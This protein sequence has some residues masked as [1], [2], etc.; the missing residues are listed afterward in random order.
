MARA[1][2]SFVCSECGHA[3]PKWQGRCPDCGAWNTMAEERIAP[4]ARAT[5]AARRPAAGVPLREVDAVAVRRLATGIGELDRV[6]GGGLVPGSL[7]LIG[8]SPGIGKSTL[9]TMA[10]AN[11]AAAGRSVLY[12]SAEESPAQVRL[13]AERLAPAALD[14]PVLAETA[15]DAVL[16]TLDAQRPQACVVDSVQTLHADGL[17]GAPGS[18]GQ[19]REAAGAI[20][21]VAKAV[22][23]AVLLVGHVTKEGALAG[24]RVLEHLVD[25]VL[26]FEGER[27]RTYRTLR[28]LKN[29]FGSVDETGVFEMRDAGLVEVLDASA[30]FVAEAT[31]APGS[32]VLAAMEGTRPLLVEVQAL[33]SES[34]LVPPR[35]VVSGIDRNRLALVLAV[36]ARHA[37]LGLGAS[38]VFV[39]VVGGVRVDE[40]GADL[41]V[42][43]AVAG[44]A[45][46]VTAAGADGA[47]PA[48]FGE[49]GLTGELR[50]VAHA[51]RRT[52]EARKFGLQPVIGP[53][54]S[55]GATEAA[56][57]REALRLALPRAERAA[58]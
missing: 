49:I 33:V 12:V 27:G 8:G 13:R 16:A 50:T 30:R 42:A 58:A 6:L 56:T 10:L 53:P 23:T 19:V 5:G 17:S 44:A 35:R 41:A 26:Q 43:L 31:R 47:P 39:N 37:G 22:G 36:L 14:V 24:P 48:C 18:V 28:A 46:G 57:L 34:E 55:S 9:T 15:L 38:D 21:R 29:R 52:A 25:C 4:A 51:D 20:M 3:E 11:L 2:S 45:R 40:P 32:V 7:V 1:R 54:G